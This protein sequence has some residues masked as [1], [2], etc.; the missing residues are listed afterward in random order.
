[1]KINKGIKFADKKDISRSKQKRESDERARKNKEKRERRNRRY[2]NQQKK[3]QEYQADPFGVWRHSYTNNRA[4][5]RTIRSNPMARF[6]I[7]RKF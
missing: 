6:K 5:K 2:A 7:E 4:I 3:L 1:M